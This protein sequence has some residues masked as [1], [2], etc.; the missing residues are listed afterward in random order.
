V[1]MGSVY[2][3]PPNSFSFN[4][5]LL[6]MIKLLNECIFFL[7]NDLFQ[8]LFGYLKSTVSIIYVSYFFMSRYL[9]P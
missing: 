8:Y 6:S 1:G 9:H 3:L 7:L 4:N 5:I 2:F